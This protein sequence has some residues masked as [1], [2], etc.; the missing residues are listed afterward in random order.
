[1]TKKQKVLL[2]LMQAFFG[3]FGVDKFLEKKILEG[4]LTVCW[5]AVL[6][7]INA[8][9]LTLNIL[10][11]A[12]VLPANI[13]FTIFAII[14]C[15]VVLIRR[16]MYFIAGLCN[17]P[18][19]DKVK[20][21]KIRKVAQL[22]TEISKGK[23]L[24]LALTQAFAGIYGVDRFLLKQVKKGVI[25]IVITAIS[26]FVV[27]LSFVSFLFLDPMSALIV[28]YVVYMI[29]FGYLSVREIIFFIRGMIFL[30][31]D[32]DEVLEYYNK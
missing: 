12:Q 27:M 29:A 1:M 5:T 11:I 31:K 15:I 20:Q 6:T 21:K 4:I 14:A 18:G 13:I 10:V 8:I 22:P 32:P 19:S 9:I 16:L 30:K 24:A 17:L 2:A 23:K 26:M 7:L 25:Q 3:E 28:V